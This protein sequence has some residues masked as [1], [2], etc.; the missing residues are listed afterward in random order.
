MKC[1]YCGEPIVASD[2]SI[3]MGC[4]NTHRNCFLRQVIGSVAHIEKR[5]SCYVDGSTAGDPPELTRRQAADAAVTLFRRV[6]K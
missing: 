1:F 6:S 4:L 5:C 3:A 2:N